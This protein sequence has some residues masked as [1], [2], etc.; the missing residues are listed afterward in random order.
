M[1][2]V[3]PTPDNPRGL[4]SDEVLR[5]RSR[6]GPNLLPA[7]PRRGLLQMAWEVMTQPMILLL[8]VTAGLY[9]LLGNRED[10]ALL[11]LSALLVGG[12]AIYQAHRTERV[13]HA[14]KDL[15]APRC[16]VIRDGQALRVGSAELVCGDR[17]VID[18]GDRLAADA[19]LVE[20][21]T[22]QVDE[23]QLTGESLPVPKH[24][25]GEGSESSL[26]AG[27]LVVQGDGV[28]VVTATGAR[29]TLGRL[30]H[31][32]QQLH[33]RPSRLEAE[34]KQLVRRVAIM[35][36]LICL[37]SSSLHAWRTGSWSE[38]LLIGL[39][40]AM[41]LIPEEFAVVWTVMLAIGA[42]RLARQGVLTREP[43]AIEALGTVS[44]L[45]VDKTGTL[46][47]NE[48]TLVALH[49]GEAPVDVTGHAP[50]ERAAALLAGA[51][52]ASLPHGI[53]PM[54]RAIFRAAGGPPPSD[55]RFTL[56]PRLGVGPGRP[57]VTHWWLD[58]EAGGTTV[59]LKGAPEALLAQC[60]GDPALL[61]RLAECAR[62]WSSEGMRVLAVVGGRADKASDDG[63]LPEGLAL[64]PL[65]LLGFRDPLRADVPAAVAACRA[66]GM[67][68]VMIT[69][70]A[71]LTARAIALQA[72][73]QAAAPDV[74]TGVALAGMSDAELRQQL[75]SVQV[76]ARVD[77]AQKLRIVQ[78][79]QQRGE[80]VAMTGD[81]V[82][83]A[84]ALRA[85]D[86]GVA[87]GQRGTDVARE[88]AA[89]VLLNDDF[90]SLVQAVRAG[91]RIFANLHQALGY[92]FAVHV[93]IV[94]VS[95]LPVL[96]GGPVLLL[97]MHVVA[98]ELII[99]PACS[100]VF[101]AEPASANS[102]RVPPRAASARLFT[103]RAA[104][105]S[106]A[107]G[108]LSFLGVL[109]VQALGHRAGWSD[110]GLRLA[111]L[112]SIVAGNLLM[113]AWFRGRHPRG[114]PGNT[115]L[116]VL[117]AGIGLGWA[118]LLALPALARVF[119]L[120]PDLPWQWALLPAAAALWCTAQLAWRRTWR[121]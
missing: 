59:W 17:L 75:A 107:V 58:N 96:M 118:A 51:M 40:L 35:A 29:T 63:S 7:A 86:I 33:R 25:G 70:D 67:R 47:R 36:L 45:C 108:G 42:W 92:L 27:S 69:G 95:L 49:D 60:S 23:S 104:L 32:L 52:R 84:P 12:L 62:S 41:S 120:P 64:A 30:G 38:G 90:A 94:G 98:L 110:E 24:P 87:M 66:A 37:V 20:G 109:L 73:L 50:G 82:N 83:D 6:D 26:S 1:N 48:M 19:R 99:D 3:P 28:A 54:D 21:G 115:A 65:G 43:Q 11:M 56:G 114:A 14:L 76:F 15:S 22:V 57:W 77:P 2:A 78:A 31:S 93:P 91:R 16:T 85:A 71:P 72:G 39:T 68:V 5:L 106:L 4:A 8:L 55:G 119:G 46:T 61:A 10:A 113:L 121:T 74:L 103:L 97:P 34:L 105:R 101:E 111:S 81:G 13:L 117:I 53:E 44:V 9:G 79:L 89:L 100:L 88:A 18:E 102:M 116:Q 80:V 112:A